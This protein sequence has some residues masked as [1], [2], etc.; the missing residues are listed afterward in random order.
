MANQKY[1]TSGSSTS[2]TDNGTSGNGTCTSGNGTGLVRTLLVE[3]TLR[4]S[5]EPLPSALSASEMEA[6]CSRVKAAQRNVNDANN[7]MAA[8]KKQDH[9]GDGNSGGDSGGDGG[10]GTGTPDLVVKRGN[11]NTNTDHASSSLDTA[12]SEDSSTSVADSVASSC[13]TSAPSSAVAG[14]VCEVSSN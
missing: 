4:S 6:I 5:S 14:A 2:T 9:Q 12:G 3:R 8:N 10:D 7:L 1:N 11:N 13:V